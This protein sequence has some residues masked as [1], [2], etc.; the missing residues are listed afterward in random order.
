M[1]LRYSLPILALLALIGSSPADG[2]PAANGAGLLAA[3]RSGWD[4]SLQS[5]QSVSYLETTSR[6]IEG[7]RERNRFGATADVRFSS[8]TGVDRTVRRTEV[9]GRR[10]PAAR[11]N[12]MN[13]RMRRAYGAGFDWVNLNPLMAVRLAGIVH[14]SSPMVADI[15]GDA[16]AWRVTTEPGQANDRIER[17]IFW[18]AQ[19]DDRPRLLRMRVVGRVPSGPGRVQGGS[20][21]I[22][23]NYRRIGG[24]DLPRSAQAEVII[25]QIRRGRI[26]TVLLNAEA[27]YSAATVTPK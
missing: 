21:L 19:A 14:P 26:F 12:A 5:V 27:T 2:Q 22:T 17:V 24:L 25:R 10:V 15:V 3:W 9:N 23:T 7:P 13:R 4:Q 18:F 1:R 8:G 11:M 20:A 16:R 6:T